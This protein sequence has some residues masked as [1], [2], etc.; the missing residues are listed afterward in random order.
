VEQPD[1]GYFIEAKSRT[2]S[3]RDAEHKA[4]LARDLIACLGSS[5][6][7]AVAEDYV[8]IAGGTC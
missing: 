5:P 2:W 4:E 7:D 6:S 8:Q 3:R 1:L